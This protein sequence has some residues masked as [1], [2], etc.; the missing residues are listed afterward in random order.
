MEKSTPIG[1]VAGLVLVFGSVAMGDGASTFFDPKSLLIVVGGTFAGLLVT[2]TMDEM[3]LCLGSAKGLFGFAM[4]DYD[5]LAEQLA[6]FARTARRDGPLALD[7]RLAEVD[8]PILTSALEMAID[9]IPADRAEATLKTLASEAARPGAMFTSFLNKAGMYAPAFGMV[10]TL[11]GLI[12]ML[13][14]LNDPSAIGPAMAVAMITTFWGALL[15]NLVFLPMAGKARTQM[16]ARA[17][18]HEMIRIG[19]IGLLTG[20][21]PAA[22]AQQ[23]APYTGGDG[24]ADDPAPLRRAA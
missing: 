11:I 12:Q 8:D 9:G 13:Q 22:I 18:A 6:D 10:G 23:L 4:P 7:A 24:Q 5:A 2:F 14:N 19:A 3:K 16:L 20:E 15:A 17:K 21:A 1:L